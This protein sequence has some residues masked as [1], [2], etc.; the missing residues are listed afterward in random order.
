MALD[1][2]TS[3][4]YCTINLKSVKLFTFIIRRFFRDYILV[5]QRILSW[6]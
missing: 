3:I 4:D 2:V 6:T 5:V 1:K